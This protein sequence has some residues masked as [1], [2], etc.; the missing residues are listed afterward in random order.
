MYSE[1]DQS[2]DLG[3]WIGDRLC[4]SIG[5]VWHGVTTTSSGSVQLFQPYLCS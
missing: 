1:L 5:I 3:V 4:L 2:G